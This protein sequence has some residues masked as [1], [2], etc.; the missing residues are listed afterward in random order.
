MSSDMPKNSIIFSNMEARRI[1]AMWVWEHEPHFNGKPVVVEGIPD[2]VTVTQGEFQH[3]SRVA[4]PSARKPTPKPPSPSPTPAPPPYLPA[5]RA[6]PLNAAEV[7]KLHYEGK[8]DEEIR[9]M[10]GCSYGTVEAFRRRHRIDRRKYPMPTPSPTPP[11]AT[12][13]PSAAPTPE[14]T[15]QPTP[16]ATPKPK[17]ATAAK[18]EA[19]GN[20]VQKMFGRAE[21]HQLRNLHEQYGYS[22][23]QLAEMH[24][25]FEECIEKG[26]KAA[27]PRRTS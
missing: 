22:I 4:E 2:T 12:P 23:P 7:R 18:G 25:T 17:R 14:P 10:F 6:K 21:A 3:D 24:G 19:P 13:V 15:P 27:P 9:K 5:A 8:S 20:R 1:I 16:E 11:G 26:L